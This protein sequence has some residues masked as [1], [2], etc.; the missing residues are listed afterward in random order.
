MRNSTENKITVLLIRHGATASN[1]AHRYCGFANDEGLS[2]E[3]ILTLRKNAERGVYPVPE[4]LFCS[5]KKRCLETAQILYPG[6]KP[7]TNSLLAEMD[8][9]EFEGKNYAELKTDSR[10]QEW[11]DSNGEKTFPGGESREDFCKRIARGYEKIMALSE[12]A[13]SIGIVA[14]GG[15]LMA[16]LF[17]FADMGYFD[18]MCENGGG[19][20]CEAE[21]GDLHSLRVIGKIRV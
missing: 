13:G 9:G 11:I 16:I 15:S 3:G 4:K 1:A 10:Y 19:F 12:D 14:H 2:G 8:F 17:V 6:M 7:V 18:G 20:I 5:S 21:Y